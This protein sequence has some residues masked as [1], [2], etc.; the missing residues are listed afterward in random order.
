MPRAK[1]ESKSAEKSAD[2]LCVVINPHA[3][4]IR[5]PGVEI[6]KPGRNLR[7]RGPVESALKAPTVKALNISVEAPAE[8]EKQSEDKAIAIVLDTFD[9]GDLEAMRAKESR[10]AVLSAIDRQIKSIKVSPKD[11]GKDRGEDDLVID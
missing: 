10:S 5:L 11:S 4:C 7:P 9:L 1:A 8:P 3:R 2:A 6:L